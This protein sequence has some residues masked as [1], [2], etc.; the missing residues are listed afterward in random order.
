MSHRGRETP[1]LRFSLFNAKP[2]KT[3]AVPAPVSLEGVLHIVL[4]PISQAL[5]LG[6]SGA[7]AC[8]LPL[9]NSHSIP[10]C[11]LPLFRFPRGRKQLAP[12]S[13]SPKHRPSAY[14]I[15]KRKHINTPRRSPKHM[16]SGVLSSPSSH[17][18]RLDWSQTIP[19]PPLCSKPFCQDVL[20]GRSMPS[21]SCPGPSF[22]GSACHSTVRHCQPPR[23][24][25]HRSGGRQSC[26][27]SPQVRTLE[28]QETRVCFAVRATLIDQS[29]VL[30]E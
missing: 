5:P 17:Y 23:D 15:A 14:A 27:H 12:F 22:R 21:P 7:R 13:L 25:L 20:A 11:F 10:I 2:P 24:S 30:P 9:Q 6:S 28:A 3:L 16:L 1:S 19:P 8:L 4:T 29:P 18:H 26:G